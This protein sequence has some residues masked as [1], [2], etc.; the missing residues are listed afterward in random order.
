M[1]SDILDGTPGVGALQG[2]AAEKQ[3]EGFGQIL[4]E[5]GYA[6]STVH[7]H[8]LVAEHFAYWTARG[9]V[10]LE[11]VDEKAISRF[12]AHLRSCHCLCAPFGPR[13]RTR[14]H[15]VYLFLGYLR[16]R[17][18]SKTTPIASGTPQPALLRDFCQWMRQRRGTCE[19]TLGDYSS[20][21]R[22]LLRLLG[23]RPEA[24]DTQRLRQFILGDSRPMGWG[25]LKHRT[26]AV[27]MFLRFLIAEGRCSPALETAIPALAH[28]RLG[29]L[30]RY[31]QEEEV[32]RLI[33]SC[34][35]ASA[36]GRR[37]R[38]MLLLLA[39]LGLRAGEVAELR[40]SDIDWRE[41]WIRVCGKDRRE[42]QLPLSQEVG[43]ALVAYITS[44]RPRCDSEMVFVRH[45]APIGPFSSSVPV[46]QTVQKAFRQ[47]AVRP[48]CRG[49]AH[50]LRHSVATSLLRHGV[51]L[52]EIATLLRHRSVETTQIYA[53]VD[54]AALEKIAQPWP[55]V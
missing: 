21:I 46:T 28:W 42:A 20:H 24:F 43:E 8:L 33:D 37:D 14:I 31:L 47:A 18:A 4:T 53:K 6:S 22:E 5:A 52:Q 32:E 50:L 27:R 16:E 23:E 2:S 9:A 41:G 17:G 39:R 30:P 7:R 51:S 45:H 10:P 26:S 38:A 44:S 3:L 25:A 11:A 36:I 55:V 48:P 12:A 13:D 35:V 29:S 15:A 34:D 54:F 19:S 49:A 40:L 1:P